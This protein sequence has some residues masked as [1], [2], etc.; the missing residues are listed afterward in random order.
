MQRGLFM[1]KALIADVLE[2]NIIND[3]NKALRPMDLQVGKI[4]FTFDERPFLI[5]NLETINSNI[6]A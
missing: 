5:I 6:Y 1:E 3:I 2:K 4:E